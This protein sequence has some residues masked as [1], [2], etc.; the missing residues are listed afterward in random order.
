MISILK[1][2][3]TEKTLK[4]R[5]VPLMTLVPVHEVTLASWFIFSA[6]QSN[7]NGLFVPLIFDC[8]FDS[9]VMQNV[10]QTFGILGCTFVGAVVVGGVRQLPDLLQQ[11]G[12]VSG[13]AV[14]GLLLVLLLSFPR[15]RRVFHHLHNLLNNLEGKWS[16]VMRESRQTS[17]ERESA[18][19][20]LTHWQ[21]LN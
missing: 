6:F 4:A 1:L 9:S 13:G 7:L 21:G 5:V 16:N 12:V 19:Q 10:C 8:L 15:V 11:G 2:Y 17:R 18:S 20:T 3:S 14:A